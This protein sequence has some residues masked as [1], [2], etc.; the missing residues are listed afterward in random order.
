MGSLDSRAALF[1]L[2][3][4]DFQPVS[5]AAKMFFGLALGALALR[6]RSLVAPA[7]AH[8]LGWIAL[9]FA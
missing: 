6:T 4:L 8:C 5:L 7:A 3:H 9:G 1:A 2:L